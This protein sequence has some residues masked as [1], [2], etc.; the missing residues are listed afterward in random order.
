MEIKTRIAPS[1]TGFLHVGTARTALFNWLFARKN[2]GKFVLRIEDTDRERSEKK[3]EDDIIAGLKWLGLDWDEMYRQSERFDIYRAYAD[4]LLAAEKAYQ[5][6]SAIILKYSAEP[7]AFNDLI[8]GEISFET[9]DQKEIVLIKS[10]GTPTYHFAV[11]ID[12]HEMGITH[13]IRGE[14]HISN[15]P[16]QI[17]IQEAL[18]LPRPIYAH[19][20][21]ILG[22]DRAKLS[23]RHGAISVNDYRARGY[24]SE[25]FV[26][27]MA[28]LGWN[29]GDERE[30]FT[31]EELV[32]EFDLDRIQKGGAIFNIEKLNWLNRQY[33]QKMSLE[34]LKKELEDYTDKKIPD[35][36]VKLAQP[37]LKALSD[38]NS[39]LRWLETPEYQAELLNWK[40]IP[41]AKTKENLEAVLA[42][43]RDLG[44]SSFEIKVLEKSLMPLASE[45][46]RG[47]VLWPLRV[48][49]SGQEK[50]PGPFELAS[51]IGK[52]ETTRR[53]ELAIKKL[54]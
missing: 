3:F 49:L 16:K 25:A 7:I 40:K 36:M 11:V 54:S 51:L 9:K 18:G 27:F 21:L 34:D 35:Q 6:G 45:R 50:S 47:E 30:L 43:L 4:K 26:N 42:I 52:K 12:D 5:E 46:G 24:L 22:P 48:A 14:D 13:V 2:K 38:I 32:K 29:P 17:M 39:E 10:D 53:L 15:T 44:E 41:A 37:R 20:P 1:P 8:R 28:L 33:I 31:I 19:L 23:K